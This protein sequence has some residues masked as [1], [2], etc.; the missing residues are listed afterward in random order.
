MSQKL[1]HL[2]EN[3]KEC[4]IARQ[5]TDY[6]MLQHTKD[7]ICMP[8]NKGKNKDIFIIFNTHCFKIN[9]FCLVS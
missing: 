1:C 8:D 9:L 2:Q 5:D 3:V 4:G 6:N 7:V